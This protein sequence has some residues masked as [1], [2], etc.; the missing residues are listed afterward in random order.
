[1][2][3]TRGSPGIATSAS[4]TVA[5]TGSPQSVRVTLDRSIAHNLPPANTPPNACQLEVRVRSDGAPVEVATVVAAHHPVCETSGRFAFTQP[6]RALGTST[7][8]GAAD[9]FHVLLEG[10]CE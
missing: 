2:T 1:V 8:F 9:A 4:T 5:G 3:L 10:H 7:T 6:L